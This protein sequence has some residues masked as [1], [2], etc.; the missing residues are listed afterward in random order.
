MKKLL[1]V[2]LLFEIHFAFGQK[3][4]KTLKQCNND[5]LAYVIYNFEENQSRYI[6][7]TMKFLLKEMDIPL[8]ARAFGVMPTSDSAGPTES[9]NKIKG[10]WFYY[11]PFYI[12]DQYDMKKRFYLV[13]HIYFKLPPY[14][15]SF[16]EFSCLKKR[17]R[18]WNSDHYH[19]FKDYEISEIMVLRCPMD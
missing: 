10:I 9:W 18:T 17:N 6:G 16:E 13:V 19:F 8:M 4:Y 14:L 5:T 3:D 12:M 7:K 2:F 11:L 15:N 1:F